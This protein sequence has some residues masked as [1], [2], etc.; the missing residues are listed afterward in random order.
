MEH[1]RIAFL[2]LR[3]QHK[4]TVQVCSR[5]LIDIYLAENQHFLA[6]MSVKTAFNLF[7]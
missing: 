2:L 1:T 3:S 6:Y 4:K 5:Y 7:A